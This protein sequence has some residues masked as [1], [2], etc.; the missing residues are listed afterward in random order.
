VSFCRRG[1]RRQNL[2]IRSTVRQLSSL[3]QTNS[4]ENRKFLPP[5]PP[6]PPSPAPA[7]GQLSKPV[8]NPFFFQDR[9]NMQPSPCF[10]E[11]CPGFVG[12]CPKQGDSHPAAACSRSPRDLDLRT[13]K[14]LSERY[15]TNRPG[16]RQ[17]KSAIP[18]RE[19]VDRAE[20]VW[21]AVGSKS[22][23]VCDCGAARVV[24]RW[25]V[26]SLRTSHE[27]DGFRHRA[28]RP[29]ACSPV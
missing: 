29:D 9:N 10:V 11:A 20:Y 15:S 23:L 13:R 16:A 25:S 21:S 3:S 8:L 28:R 1:S 26:Q 2:Q 19:G 14:S 12:A 6:R 24:P 18:D 27:L 4:C 5:V 7:V 22:D 17:E